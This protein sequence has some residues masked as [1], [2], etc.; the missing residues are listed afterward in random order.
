MAYLVLIGPMASGKSH[1]GKKIAKLAQ[2]KFIDT[3]KLI[4]RDHGV[5]ADIFERYGEKYFR[6]IEHKAVEEALEDP[7]AV[8]SLGGGAPMIEANQLLL[9]NERVALL[10]MSDS[11]AKFRLS[12]SRDR[13]LLQGGGFDSWKEI[14]SKRMP[15]YT[16]LAGA[17][18][19]TSRGRLDD[20]AKNI[21]DWRE[22]K[23]E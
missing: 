16:K 7:D 20:I 3:D 6:E 12:L 5:I 19:D 11:S 17:Q 1:I 14:T 9:K 10:T 2:R 18:F 23:N 22:G 21:L 8:I 13:P 15:I 4:V